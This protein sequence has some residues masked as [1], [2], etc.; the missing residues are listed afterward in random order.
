[1]AGR[2]D[3][4]LAVAGSAAA[5][6]R[7]AV[8]GGA[9]GIAGL[10]PEL[11]DLVAAAYRQAIGATFATG[12]V[13]AGLGLLLRARRETPLRPRP[14]RQSLVVRSDRH[15]PSRRGPLRRV[16]CYASTVPAAISGETNSAPR[17]RTTPKNCAVASELRSR[18]A[19]P[20]NCWTR[21]GGRS[22]Q[23]ERW[24]F[25]SPAALVAEPFSPSR[26]SGSLPL[27]LWTSHWD[28]YPGYHLKKQAGLA[29]RRSLVG[30]AA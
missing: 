25:R 29:A 6:A 17:A 23:D 21:S 12:A 22:R 30:E 15:L 27:S 8:A 28:R 11:H 16:A 26:P 1:L 13:I 5:A 7:R 20:P 14:A 9:G 24:R 2:V 3:A 4:L 19:R 18:S 10:P